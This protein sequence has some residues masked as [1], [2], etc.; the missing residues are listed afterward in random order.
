MIDFRGT[1]LS[2]EPPQKEKAEF[3]VMKNARFI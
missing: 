2:K 1:C 3:I